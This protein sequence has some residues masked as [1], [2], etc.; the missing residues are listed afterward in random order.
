MAGSSTP[1]RQF[2]TTRWTLVLAA[3]RDTPARAQAALAELCQTYWYP[4][5]A[6]VRRRGHGPQDAED[7]TQA[8]LARLLEKRAVAA[9]RRQRGKFRAFLLS[10]LTHFLSDEWDKARAQKRGGRKEIRLDALS[11]ETRYA[12][13]GQDRLTAE[14]LF[15]RQWALRLLEQVLCR[16]A[17]EFAAAGK[18][19]LFEQLRDCLTGARAALPYAQLARQL[20]MTEGAVKVAVHRLRQRYRELLFEEIAQ[21]VATPEDV[22]EELRDLFRALAE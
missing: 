16:L 5:Y 13:Q 21:T 3:G 12:A 19:K 17:D 22:Q 18:A 9:A 8:F 1:H 14:K 11:A 15:D 6:Y 7:L 2:A 4:L 20:G 10:S